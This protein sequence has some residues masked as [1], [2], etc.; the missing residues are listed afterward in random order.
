MISNTMWC[1]QCQQDVPAV[2]SAPGKS[3]NCPRCKVGLVVGVP[4][5]EANGTRDL[6]SRPV[7]DERPTPSTDGTAGMAPEKSGRIHGNAPGID[8]QCFPPFAQLDAKRISA[9]GVRL[10]SPQ[11]VPPAPKASRPALDQIGVAPSE[12][13]GEERSLESLVTSLQTANDPPI[14]V[15]ESRAIDDIPPTPPAYDSWELEEQLRHIDRILAATVVREPKSRGRLESPSD[16]VQRGTTASK[17]GDG[18]GDEAGG[19]RGDKSKSLFRLDAAHRQSA[20]RRHALAKKRRAEARMAKNDAS[21]ADPDE[22]QRLTWGLL[23]G[24]LTLFACGGLLLL[25]SGWT[26]RQDL[27]AIGWPIAMIGQ[28]SLAVGGVLLGDRLWHESATTAA[29]LDDVDQRL[30]SLLAVRLDREAD[31]RVA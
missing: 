2:Y 12:S 25:W 9:A 23:S 20:Q 22:P 8:A 31:G 24:G 7:A 28:I 1:S 18:A 4:D 30:D 6:R 26:G 14:S 11:G 29:K 21:D 15:D 16:A 17:V 10:D 3:Y 27:W 5:S 13:L 19:K